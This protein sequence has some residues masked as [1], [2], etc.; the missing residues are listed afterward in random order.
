MEED[1]GVHLGSGKLR[2]EGWKN[3]DFQNADINCDIRKLPFPDNSEDI[4]VAI[5][6]FEHLYQWE[7]KEAI[8]EWARILKPG[9]KLILEMPDMQKVLTYMFKCM[10]GGISP[11]P[12]FS[13]LA[14][15]GDPKYKNQHMC[16]KWGYFPSDILRIMAECGLVAHEEPAKYHFPERDMRIVG[17]KC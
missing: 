14:I 8:R 11:S 10:N 3:V 5:H 4:V 7:G 15:W 12:N 16:H 2:W 1:T 17:V 6:V 9:G 13:W